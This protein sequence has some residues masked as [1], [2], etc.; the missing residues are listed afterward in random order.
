MWHKRLNHCIT[1]L[2]VDDD[3]IIGIQYQLSSTA[4]VYLFQVYLPSSNHSI[5]VFRDYIDIVYELKCQ[6]TDK[7]VVIFMG[8]FNAHIKELDTRGIYLKFFFK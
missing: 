5:N 6:Y 3:R 1:P 8:D 2:C 4:Y 7:G